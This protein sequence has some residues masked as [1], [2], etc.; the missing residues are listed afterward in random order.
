MNIETGLLKIYKLEMDELEGY[1]LINI[2]QKY[3]EQ[4]NFKTKVSI[5]HKM[6]ILKKKLYKL[7]RYVYFK[8]VI[9][10]QTL[11]IH[12]PNTGWFFCNNFL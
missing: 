11:I 9:K 5:I 6:A 12:S 3:F 2:Q 8:Y 10:Y 7:P 4:N 1:E